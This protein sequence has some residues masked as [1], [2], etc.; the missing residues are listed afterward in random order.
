VRELTR[1]I[2]HCTAT[3]EGRDVSVEEI[4][5]WH[6]SPPRN[7]SD[8]GY[9]YVILATG[10]TLDTIMSFSLTGPL[11]GADR[12]MLLEPTS[13]GTI[14]ILLVWSMLAVLIAMATRRTR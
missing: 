2:L 7:W 3:P 9:H 10:Q 14:K 13:V 4:R 8:I 1:I 11:S 6:T 12:L 5:G